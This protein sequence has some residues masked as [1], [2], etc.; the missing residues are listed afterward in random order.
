MV[1]RQ[2]AI[3]TG[4]KQERHEAILDAAERLLARSPD[5]VASVAEVAD[6]EGLAK[7]IVYLY[8]PS[9]EELLLA[10]HER[11]ID[12]FFQ[13]VIAMAE[14]DADVGVD[15]M[16]ELTHHH[17]VRPA[18]FLPLAARC[19]GQMAHGVPTGAALAFK[20]RM[21]ERL[22]RAGAG[23]E[24]HFPQLES[25]DGVALFRR[26]YAL[27]LGLWQMSASSGDGNARCAFAESDAPSP[28]FESRYAD[29]IDQ[30]LRALWNGT[31]G[32]PSTGAPRSEVE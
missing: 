29:E 6:D 2:R 7:G 30:A 5:R 27:I 4:D 28:V 21:A 19:F 22:Q 17:M 14:S 16:L 12:G 15:E 13:A 26:S 10:L 9:K 18:L 25:G 23:I 20:Q 11:N 3:Q 31:V 32:T 1:I 8:F 24:R